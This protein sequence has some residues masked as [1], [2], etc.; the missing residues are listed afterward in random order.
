MVGLIHKMLLDMLIDDYGVAT[1]ETILKRAEI[2][3]S[4]DFRIDTSYSDS[5]FREILK[6]T[7]EETG[8]DVDAFE[9]RFAAHFLQDALKRWPMW[10]QMSNTAKS[11]LERQPKIHNGFASS[12][13]NDQDRDK[14][15]DKF[16][17]DSDDHSITVHYVSPNQLCGLYKALALE[18][19][20]YYHD[21]AIIEES[22]CQKRGD[23]ECCIR[24][25]WDQ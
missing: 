22:T 9:K 4:Q 10:F 16:R 14:I 5:Q 6:I 15:N 13:S 19:L 12:M 23:H 1:L 7:L 11:F 2:T 25:V 17:V 21:Q 18:I 20:N 8:L 24:V 3:P